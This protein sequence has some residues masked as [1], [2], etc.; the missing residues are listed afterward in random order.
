MKKSSLI[1]K[2][3]EFLKKHKLTNFPK[4]LRTKLLKEKLLRLLENI[5]IMKIFY[6]RLCK[7]KESNINHIH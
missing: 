5:K 1:G 3:T 6:I 7:K 2:M 4:N